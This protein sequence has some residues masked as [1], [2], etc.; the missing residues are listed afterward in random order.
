M[1]KEIVSHV[2][3]VIIVHLKKGLILN[4]NFMDSLTSISLI[5]FPFNSVPSS[6]LMAFFR[7]LLFANSKVLISQTSPSLKS[8]KKNIENLFL[9]PHIPSCKQLPIVGGSVRRE[10]AGE[11]RGC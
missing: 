4:R 9:Y 1:R 2:I 3:K 7:S 10:N 8:M 6:F 5:R 11:E